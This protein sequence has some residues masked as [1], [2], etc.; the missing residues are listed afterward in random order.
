MT[1]AKLLTAG[2]LACLLAAGCAAPMG[3]DGVT[4]SEVQ[5]FG[6]APTSALRTVNFGGQTPTSI[7]G[8]RRVTT[9]EVAAAL[10]ASP[11]AILIDVATGSGHSSLPGAAWLPRGGLGTSFDDETQTRLVAAAERLTGG[12]RRRPI[13]TFCPNQNC[14]LS[15]NAA[16]RLSRAGFTEV[17]WYRGGYMA[18]AEA[19]RPI[20]RAVE[21]SW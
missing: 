6:V 2:L 16:L 18:W 13:I 7:P 8:A 1:S 17:R 15:Y 11:P 4:S 5:E 9:P 14:W 10:A 19:G 21:A 12:D 3:P 20:A